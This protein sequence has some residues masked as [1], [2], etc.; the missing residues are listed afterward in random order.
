MESLMSYLDVA[1]M[2]VSLRT[3]PEDFEMLH[4]WLHHFPSSHRFHFDPKGQIS[5]DARCDCSLLAVQ[6]EQRQ[7]LN[8]AFQQWHAA[9]WRPVEIN[10]E[11]ASHFRPPNAWQR[12]WRRIMSRLRR[13]LIRD[14]YAPV[15]RAVQVPVPLQ[16]VA[17]QN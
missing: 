17:I 3:R 15:P 9:Y 8:E 2:A 14:D 1:P 7:E 11:F 16:A 10:R 5:I 12:L 6:P 13:A 4:G